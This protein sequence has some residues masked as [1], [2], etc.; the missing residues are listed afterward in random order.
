MSARSN[1]FW[2][3]WHCHKKRLLHEKNR[4][5]WPGQ[6][7]PLRLKFFLSSRTCLLHSNYS[8]TTTS[9]SLVPHLSISNAAE[10]CGCRESFEREPSNMKRW[11]TF[12]ARIRWLLTKKIHS[13][14]LVNHTVWFELVVFYVTCFQDFFQP[15]V[16]SA[17][18]AK[19][20][21]DQRWAPSQAFAKNNFRCNA[22]QSV[23]VES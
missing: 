21:S 17:M 13:Y 2:D 5:V 19:A 3:S 23:L 20:P 10:H 14:H 8:D 1:I 7:V 22:S 11:D 16:R 9:R 18:N 15:P 4:N 6:L 12:L